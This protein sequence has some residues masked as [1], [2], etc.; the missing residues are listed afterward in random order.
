MSCKSPAFRVCAPFSLKIFLLARD[1][2][3]VTVCGIESVRLTMALSSKSRIRSTQAWSSKGESFFSLASTLYAYG[4]SLLNCTSK[5]LHS[6]L[7][8]TGLSDLK[9]FFLRNTS[10]ILLFS[11]LF[12]SSIADGSPVASASSSI[13]CF[14]SLPFCSFSAIS[15]L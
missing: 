7:F 2:A 6:A 9:S 15:F 12:R 11:K 14:S 8:G 10:T 1:F 3:V 5:A 13:V 4:I